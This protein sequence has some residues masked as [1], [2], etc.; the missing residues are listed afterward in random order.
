[1]TNKDKVKSLN[2]QQAKATKAN[3]YKAMKISSFTKCK[4]FESP[5]NTRGKQKTM[6]VKEEIKK[7]LK[8]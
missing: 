4:E 8:K 2:F 3:D 7:K 6:K 1:M 5:K